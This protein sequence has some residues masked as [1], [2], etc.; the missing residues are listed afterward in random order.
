MSAGKQHN[1]AAFV[2]FDKRLQRFHK[3]H[4]V[5]FVLLATILGLILFGVVELIDWLLKGGQ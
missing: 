1:H 5:L 2:R 4:P 3:Q